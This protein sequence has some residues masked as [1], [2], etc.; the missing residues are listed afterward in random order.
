MDKISILIPTRE[1]YHLLAKC[2]YH[3][4]EACANCSK[5]FKYETLVL[6]GSSDLDLTRQVL[7]QFDIPNL[8]L[9]PV[10]Q[11]WNFSQ[12]N[13][14]GVSISKGDY[15]L[16]LNNDCYLPNDFFERTGH[17]QKELRGYILLFPDGS[18]QHA[19]VNLIERP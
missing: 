6:D 15:Y 10:E 17:N 8:K 13:N 14:Y 18:I 19:G 7:E 5:F 2:L 11:W 12:I 3:I 16:F 1:N 4:Q 9:V